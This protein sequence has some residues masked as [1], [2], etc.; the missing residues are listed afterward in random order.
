MPAAAVSPSCVLALIFLSCSVSVVYYFPFFRL[1][2]LFCAFFVSTFEACFLRV[3]YFSVLI[4]LRPLFWRFLGVLRVV[5]CLFLVLWEVLFCLFLFDTTADPVTHSLRSTAFACSA[6]VFLLWAVASLFFVGVFGIVCVP[7]A[8]LPLLS[9]FV[10]L[11]FSLLGLLF[12][13]FFISRFSG[14]WLLWCS[15]R[16]LLAYLPRL[17]RFFLPFLV[18]SLSPES[19]RWA[20]LVSPFYVFLSID[21][22]CDD[23]FFFCRCRFVSLC[24]CLRSLAP[25]C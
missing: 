5:S 15:L 2:S 3:G 16:F 11:A 8:G 20:W 19:F 21:S 14:P 18:S 23:R 10:L 1:F 9:R 13:V 22:L 17:L 7:V 4:C 6:F 25:G 12:L 24:G